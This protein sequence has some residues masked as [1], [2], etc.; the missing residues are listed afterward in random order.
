MSPLATRN[1]IVKSHALGN[2]YLVVDPA[3]LTF[4]LSP[5]AIRLICHRHLGAG[6]DGILA[7]APSSRADFGLRIYNPD[8]S[9]AEKSGNGL[10][11]FAKFLFDHGYARTTT[12]TVETPGGVAAI[13][14]HLDGGRV[15]SLTVDVG[16]ATFASAEIP[17]AGPHREVLDEPIEV[18]GA[19]FAFTGVSVGNPHC[20]IFVPDLAQ[21]DL[22]RFGPRLET[23]PL[24]PNRT[25]VQFA[26]VVARDRVHILIWERG[27]GETMASGT[28]ASAV[29]AAAVRRGAT[30]RALVV[31][32]PGGDLRIAVGEDWS[33]RMTGPASEVYSG[34]LSAEL[35]AAVGGEG[36]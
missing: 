9:E 25:N 14:L 2:D 13:E 31:S 11:I 32:A 8:G 23:H 15:V 6:S 18:D 30:D 26:Q 3:A 35:I 27:A 36:A 17:V 21:V 24:F 4:P 34:V 5:E 12:F 1:W 29:A 20:V 33:I 7:L 28:S 16:R 22:R 19:R 10:R